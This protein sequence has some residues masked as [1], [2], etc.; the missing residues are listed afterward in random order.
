M[1]ANSPTFLRTLNVAAVFA[2]LTLN[3]QIAAEPQS[4]AQALSWRV[5]ARDG[6]STTHE[7]TV[8]VTNALTGE[9]ADR[10]RRVVGLGSGLNYRNDAGEYVESQDLVELTADGGAGA[11]HGPAKVRFNANLNTAGAITL[12]TVS[13]RVL[14][15]HPLCLA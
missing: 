3:A 4:P 5:T 12:T 13:N 7:L 11:V 6:C 2:A 8:L 1:K 9:V 10:S 15:T 14:R